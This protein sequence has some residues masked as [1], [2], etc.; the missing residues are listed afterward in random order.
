[1]SKFL[2]PVQRAHVP[3]PT[4]TRSRSTGRR[5]REQV[6]HDRSMGSR[7]RS[8]GTRARRS[9]RGARRQGQGSVKVIV[10]GVSRRQGLP[11][12]RG[13]VPSNSLGSI[14]GS[15]RCFSGPDTEARCSRGAPAASRFA[16]HRTF[17]IAE[18]LSGAR[19]LGERLLRSVRLTLSS[20]RVRSRFGHLP[21]VGSVAVG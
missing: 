6:L 15:P 9:G 1:M 18:H 11:I 12:S 4:G 14:A 21:A 10:A 19:P 17:Q 7:S 13:Q 5:D 20:G 3:A 16:R 8:S 2:V